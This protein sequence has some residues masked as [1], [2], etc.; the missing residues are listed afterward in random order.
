MFLET[1][2][3]FTTIYCMILN[4]E[5]L[6]K[7]FSKTC[8]KQLNRNGFSKVAIFISCSSYVPS[9][10]QHSIIRRNDINKFDV[11][12]KVRKANLLVSLLA[13]KKSRH[14]LT[15]THSL[16]PTRTGA[17]FSPTTQYVVLQTLARAF[18]K[19]LVFFKLDS[20]TYLSYNYHFYAINVGK[21]RAWNNEH[22]TIKIF[23]S[24][25]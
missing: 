19:A 21:S 1:L 5:E 12:E 23:Y 3:R 22:R 14:I 16:L 9:S 6:L 10:S 11:I 20:N 2:E 4:Y 17:H 7:H 8:I 18:S 15:P 13:R 25:A 24:S